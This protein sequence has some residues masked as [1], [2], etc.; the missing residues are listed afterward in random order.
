MIYQHCYQFMRSTTPVSLCK[1][2]HKSETCD[3][4]NYQIPLF[5]TLILPL[6]ELEPMSIPLPVAQFVVER[7]LSSSGKTKLNGLLI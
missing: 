7:N 3:T 6:L 1:F 4:N 5:T 2:L